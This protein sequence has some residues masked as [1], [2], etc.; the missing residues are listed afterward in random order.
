MAAL[1][2]RLQALA[3][4]AQCFAKVG[5][6]VLFI[7]RLSQQRGGGA[8]L[9]WGLG[10]RG[11]G[12]LVDLL[13]LLLTRLQFALLLAMTLKA[14]GEWGQLSLQLFLTRELMTLRR[15]LLQQFQILALLA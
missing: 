9:T 11:L 5:K 15:Q 7:E 1:F 3:S 12:G 13:Q 10:E 14:F 6:V 8:C 4:F 2:G